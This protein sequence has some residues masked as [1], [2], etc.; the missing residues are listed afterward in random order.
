LPPNPDAER[1]F[2]IYLIRMRF[3]VGLQVPQPTISGLQKYEHFSRFCRA[4]RI[5]WDQRGAF[6]AASVQGQP[7]CD[8]NESSGTPFFWACTFPLIPYLVAVTLP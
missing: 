2:D 8:A 7:R 3:W 4:G 5:V 1:S 6:G